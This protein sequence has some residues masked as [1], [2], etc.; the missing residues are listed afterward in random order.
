M[1]RNN[2]C[3]LLLINCEKNGVR[4]PVAPKIVNVNNN[5]NITGNYNLTSEE[6]LGG[7]ITIKTATGNYNLT[8]PKA[9]ELINSIVELHNINYKADLDVK[10]FVG[11]S[12][13][14]L[15]RNDADDQTLIAPDGVELIG[16]DGIENNYNYFIRFIITKVNE[17]QVY[18]LDRLA[19]GV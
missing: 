15:L 9:T 12:F 19:G 3:D 7:L 11:Y 13:E 18:V 16:Y 5:L 10:L 2:N 4:L 8:L 1:L 17:V 6:L 14:V